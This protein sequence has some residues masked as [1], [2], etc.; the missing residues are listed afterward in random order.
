MLC[1]YIIDDIIFD[2]PS[3]RP[4]R[5]AVDVTAFNTHGEWSWVSAAINF[6]TKMLL[7]IEVS[8]DFASNPRRCF[9]IDAL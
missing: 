3:T 8:A 1:L 5:V 7:D 9:C 2:P 6:E 4:K